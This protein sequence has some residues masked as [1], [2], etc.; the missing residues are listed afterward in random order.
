MKTMVNE[1]VDRE[2]CLHTIL[3]QKQRKEKRKM[4]NSCGFIMIIVEISSMID[5]H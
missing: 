1:L 2:S 4:S 3:T 5:G